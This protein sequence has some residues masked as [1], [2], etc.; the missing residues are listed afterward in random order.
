MKIRNCIL[1]FLRQGKVVSLKE[2]TI[3]CKSSLKARSNNV[4]FTQQVYEELMTM[5]KEGQVIRE[6]MMHPPG[7]YGMFRLNQQILGEK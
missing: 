2:A 6:D 7:N 1:R 3:L 4:V 5:V